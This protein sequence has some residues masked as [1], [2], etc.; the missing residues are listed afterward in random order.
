L[1]VDLV[2]LLYV[3]V[4]LEEV[5]EIIDI[6]LYWNVVL[7]YWNFYFLCWNIDDVKNDCL[8]VGYFD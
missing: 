8:F 7:L 2:D 5:F 6:G 3:W 4:G 1:I